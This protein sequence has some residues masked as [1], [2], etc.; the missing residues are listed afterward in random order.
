V[1]SIPWTQEINFGSALLLPSGITVFLQ[2]N[3]YVAIVLKGSS[4][5]LVLRDYVVYIRQ[6]FR[7][8]EN[9]EENT[10]QISHK[11]VY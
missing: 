7:R 6:I 3:Q 5:K 11:R 10:T 9:R 4:A 1:S 8:I 2:E